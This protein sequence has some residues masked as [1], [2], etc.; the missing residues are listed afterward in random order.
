V[1]KSYSTTTSLKIREDLPSVE[2]LQILASILKTSVEPELDKVEV[3]RLQIITTPT[4]TY[5]DL[6]AD[7]INY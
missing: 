3:Q 1:S 4:R 7:C 2:A 5:R 6:Q